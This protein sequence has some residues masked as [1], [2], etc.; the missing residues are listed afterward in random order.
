VESDPNE[1]G[2][3]PLHTAV[4]HRWFEGVQDLLLRFPA[5]AER[6]D[7]AAVM[8]IVNTAICESI[9]C[10]RLFLCAGNSTETI[11]AL[12]HLSLW[13]FLHF[14]AHTGAWRVL[15]DALETNC[16]A[17]SIWWQQLDGMAAEPKVTPLT[18]ACKNGHLQYISPLFPF[19]ADSLIKAGGPERLASG[20]CKCRSEMADLLEECQEDAITDKYDGVRTLEEAARLHA[21]SVQG[22]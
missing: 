4:G 1:V 20:D 21:S 2:Q 22:R 6:P 17:G 9:E 8:S 15:K 3:N 18:L 7:V 10:F 13:T 19:G 12:T 5:L 14:A 16:T 11:T